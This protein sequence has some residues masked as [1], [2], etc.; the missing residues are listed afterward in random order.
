MAQ[1]CT[2]WLLQTPLSRL[3]SQH[4]FSAS[5]KCRRDLSAHPS[6]IP[7]LPVSL[8]VSPPTHLPSYTPKVVRRLWGSPHPT[9]VT[10]A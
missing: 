8:P 2:L 6:T 5:T 10:R 3:F 1:S 7:S 9:G 4:T